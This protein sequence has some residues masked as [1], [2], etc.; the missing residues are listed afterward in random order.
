[1][2]YGMEN[3]LR[4]ARTVLP[5]SR[6][7]FNDP[8]H[9]LHTGFTPRGEDVDQYFKNTTRLSTPGFFE[10]CLPAAC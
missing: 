4:N 8:G 1:M 9:F 5:G 7:R 10:A 6:S 2:G 3:R